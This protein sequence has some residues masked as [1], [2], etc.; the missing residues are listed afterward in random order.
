MNNEKQ[1]K[2]IPPDKLQVG[3]NITVLNWNSHVDYSYVGDILN[4]KAINLPF[5]IIF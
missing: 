3:V 1:N 2:I 4:I 5:I